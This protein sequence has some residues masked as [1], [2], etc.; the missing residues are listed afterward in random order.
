MRSDCR[1]WPTAPATIQPTA[2]LS[3]RRI[4]G[5]EITFVPAPNLNH[6]LQYRERLDAAD[7]WST[8]PG[9]P[10]NSGFY[11]ERKTESQRFYRLAL[12]DQAAVR[13]S[14]REARETELTFTPYPGVN[15]T[16]QYRDTLRVGP[17]W[18]DLPGGP[19]NAGRVIDKTPLPARFYRLKI[20]E[21]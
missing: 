11:V 17:D 6:T 16:V 10:H 21:P 4:E 9:A 14:I 19:H 1:A 18:S 13:L 3:I 2:G 7:P 5:I 8:I 15:Y 20:S 12:S